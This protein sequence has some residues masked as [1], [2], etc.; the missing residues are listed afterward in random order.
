MPAAYKRPP[1]GVA[2]MGRSDTRK[3]YRLPLA[4]AALALSQSAKRWLPVGKAAVAHVGVATVTAQR[5]Q[6]GL[7]HFF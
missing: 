4:R 2:P 1:A 5:R 7:R 6:E 3:G